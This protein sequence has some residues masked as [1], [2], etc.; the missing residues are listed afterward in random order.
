MQCALRG[1]VRAGGEVTQ[2]SARVCASSA[3]SGTGGDQGA[4]RCRMLCGS[5][6]SSLAWERCAWPRQGRA[7]CSHPLPACWRVWAA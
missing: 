7:Y 6:A 5:H 3:S 2:N 4:Y 1:A